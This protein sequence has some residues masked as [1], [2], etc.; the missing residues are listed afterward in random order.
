M[1]KFFIILVLL[2]CAYGAPKPQLLATS[3][4]V[5]VASHSVPVATSYQNSF[6]VVKTVPNV[7]YGV[8]ALASAPVAYAAGPSLLRSKFLK[9]FDP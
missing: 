7:A 6:Q 3:P 1:L 9:L 4:V 5:A 8:H 2:A